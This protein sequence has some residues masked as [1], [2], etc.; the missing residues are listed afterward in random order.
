[1]ESDLK[2]ATFAALLTLGATARRVDRE[3][4]GAGGY[5]VQD[6][7]WSAMARSA[8]RVVRVQGLYC[9]VPASVWQASGLRAITACAAR[10]LEEDVFF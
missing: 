8:A 4:V 5:C 9:D 10:V 2:Q 3:R 7:L 6:Q 1:M